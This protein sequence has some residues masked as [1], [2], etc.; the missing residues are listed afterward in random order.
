MAV[1]WEDLEKD[2]LVRNIAT[3]EVEQRIETLE[4]MVKSDI[5]R[6]C[7]TK[8][9]EEISGFMLDIKSLQSEFRKRVFEAN[10]QKE[11]KFLADCKAVVKWQIDCWNRVDKLRPYKTP[12]PQA[13]A[14]SSTDVASH[15]AM[16]DALFTLNT[17]LQQSNES[18]DMSTNISKPHFRGGKDPY[19]QFEAYTKSFKTYS[20]KVQ[21]KVHLLQ[22]L[23][24]TLGGDAFKQIAELEINADNYDLAWDRLNYVYKKPQECLALLVDKIFTY[25]FTTSIDKFDEN[26]NNYNILIDKL[27][28]NY[29]IDL[30]DNDSGVHRVIS[31]LTFKKFPNSI[32]NIM[33]QLCSTH[34]P[35]YEELKKYVP[36]AVDRIKKFQNSENDPCNLTCNVSSTK[37]NNTGNNQDIK[38]SC[39][40]CGKDNHFTSYCMKFSTYDDRVNQLKKLNRCTF[41]GKVGHQGRTKDKCGKVTCFNCKRDGHMAILCFERIKSLPCNKKVSNNG[42]P[43]NGKFKKKGGSSVNIASIKQSNLLSNAKS[44]KTALP[45]A[46]VQI[47]QKGSLVNCNM[48]FDQGSQVTLISKQYVEKLHLKANGTKLMQICGVTGEGK[49]ELYK[50]YSLN[51]HTNEGIINITAIAYD[52]LPVIEMPG[53]NRILDNLKSEYKNLAD[54]PHN[55]DLINVELLLGC[56]N[57]YKLVKNTN[58]K[59]SDTL[60][61]MPTK[62]GHVACGPYNIDSESYNVDKCNS[63]F[64][65]NNVDNACETFTRLSLN[66]SNSEEINRNTVLSRIFSMENLVTNTELQA[67]EER[68]AYQTFDNEIYF[69]KDS[70]QYCVPLLFKGGYPPCNLPTNYSLTVKRNNL[71]KQQLD[72]P[73]FHK[74]R[75]LL[76]E[77]CLKERELKFIE[78]VPKNELDTNEGHFLPAVLVEKESSSTPLRRCFDCSAKLKNKNS[79]NDTLF[80]GQN[81]VPKIFDIIIR[82]RFSRYFLLC[83]ISKAFLRLT[84][85]E[86][87]RNYV[88]IILREDWSDPK[89][90]DIIYRFRTVLFGSSCSP[91]LLQATISHHLKKTNMQHLL[92]NL[93]VDDISFFQNSA[94][95]LLASQNAAVKVFNQ[96][97]M[98]LAKY[99]SNNKTVTKKLVSGGL[100][101]KPQIECKLLGMHIDL[102]SDCFIIKLPKFNI[103][104]PTLTSVLSDHASVWDVVGFIEPVR[105]A[106]KVFINSLFREK[107]GW[108]DKLNKDQIKS[109]IN[110]VNLFKENAVG[111]FFRMCTNKPEGQHTLHVLTD[112]SAI[113]YGAVAYVCTVEKNP[114]SYFLCS[115]SK[116]KGSTSKATIPKLE[117]CG[118]LFGLDILEKLVVI[119]QKSHTFVSLHLWSDAKVPLSW[120]C[121]TFN[122]SLQFINNRT[123]RAKQI[124]EK[125]KIKLHYIET[126]KNPADLLTKEFDKIYYKLSLWTQGPD[127]IRAIEFPEFKTVDYEIG[128]GNPD[129]NVYVNIVNDDTQILSRI[130][131]VS[132]LNSL[133]K[134]THIL[135][136]AAKIIFSNKLKDVQNSNPKLPPVLK[137]KNGPRLTLPEI[138]PSEINELFFIWVKYIQSIYFLNILNHFKGLGQKGGEGCQCCPNGSKSCSKEIHILNGHVKFGNLHL[139]IDSN[140]VLR[141]KT[142]ASVNFD[143]NY[144][145]PVLL[146][147]KAHFSSLFAQEIHNLEGH[148]GP[149]Q[150]LASCRQKVWIINGRGVIN[151]IVK[152][153]SV[154]KL[155]NINLYKTPHFPE[156]PEIRMIY[157]HPFKHIGMDM[158]GHYLFHKKGIEFK[159]YILIIT[160]LSSRAVHALVCKD[161]SVFSLIHCLR[162]H[163]YRYGAPQ[164]ILTDNAKNF[165]SLNSILEK[166]S[167]TELVKQVLRTR[168]ISWK[169]TPNYSPW[170]GAVFESM[171]KIVKRILKKTFT[172]M[173]MSEDDMITLVSHAEYVANNR[174]ISYVTQNDEFN[175]LTPNLLIFGRPVHQVNWLDNDF[176]SD[177]DYTI[178]NQNV[179]GDAFKKLRNS[180]S[181]I[182]KDFNSMYL[183]M[184][185]E[186][187]AKQLE[188]KVG[189]KRNITSR[190]P[191]VGDVVLLVDEHGRPSRM[192]R[193]VEIS[194]KNCAE[195]R[196]CKVI[197][198]NTTNWWPVSRI[199]FFEVGSP[200]TIPSK[201]QLSKGALENNIVFPRSKLHRLAKKDINYSE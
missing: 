31:H 127:T 8:M 151:K 148:V 165:Q 128:N 82:S 174:P 23:R 12:F 60:T 2:I 192:S 85:I 1:T 129:N 143:F 38:Q 185:K 180:M 178:V 137:L 46:V 5:S 109:W 155:H 161:N 160:C 182:E 105:V 47:I 201:F 114:Q 55:A 39:Y 200:E 108:K 194:G 123:Q 107:L 3:M 92:E 163:I 139:I 66:I 80:V 168:G 81:L 179:L 176:F 106:S 40:L 28:T 183:D 124:L 41:C 136:N 98:P 86:K 133:F 149:N 142:R 91:F 121:S 77:L 135:K 104:D 63:N 73:K 112:A 188:S 42:L 14:T 88:K 113:G 175:I 37:P 118:I 132:S 71:L 173:K 119:L 103:T 95:E 97:S 61:L 140:Q 177:P 181:Q 59:M 25:Q 196:S 100:L 62:V 193:I 76:S 11:D 54:Y 166:N 50:T 9:Y 101:N 150:T 141:V 29:S 122:H 36:I 146:P 75:K 117:L 84:L 153:C 27:K 44:Y 190:T 74:T 6:T 184:L 111:N 24:D 21:D 162:R 134:V 158:S 90:K 154:C 157:S 170:A 96:I 125:Y 130:K 167:K 120:I 35:T 199:S 69:D 99:V 93:F 22:L 79:L 13:A 171:V 70:N 19:M 67:I 147:Q 10:L 34:Y 58:Y 138:A 30:L 18:R 20:R 33:L 53:Y 26:F 51:I 7:Y 126:Q 45:F 144:R 56:D 102:E 152:N 64:V 87:Y 49:N 4:A 16:H 32:K 115:K 191:A 52:T 195:V 110:I 197:L 15:S 156:L 68:L 131:E 72:T 43:D 83:D 89:S 48:L 94:E 17:T 78:P 164:T 159:R 145:F 186:R 57:Y 116:L 187:D 198:N 189:R 169:F 65:Y 172:S